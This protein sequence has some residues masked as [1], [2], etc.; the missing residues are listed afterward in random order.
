M[1]KKQ[2][3][4]FCDEN[5]LQIFA[6]AGIQTTLFFFIRL[7]SKNLEHNKKITTFYF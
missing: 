7:S 6:E 2:T 5:E 3:K 4:I 1:S